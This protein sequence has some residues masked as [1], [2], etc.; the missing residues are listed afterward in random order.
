MKKEKVLEKIKNSLIISAQSAS[1]EPFH[2]ECAMNALIDT[3]VMLGEIDALRLAGARD[4]SNTRKKYPNVTIIGITK[5][6]IIPKNYKELVYI[7]P[8]VKDAQ[9]VA[10]SGAD[11]VAFDA[12]IRKRECAICE[13]ISAVH[14]EGKIAMADIA[15]FEDAQNAQKCGADIV[16][17][18][19]SGYTKET[20]NNAPVPDFELLKMCVDKLDIPV[21]LEGKI[22]DKN[23]VKKAFEIGAHAVVI[24]SAVTR[25]HLIIQKFKEGLIG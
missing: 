19:L 6:D 3:V 14:F 5:P 9:N 17:T 13:I 12:T 11:I 2:E 23:D 8:S 4:I 16:S 10:N 18:T 21:I 25:P 15:T 1:G 22:W 7:T 20:E 24:G